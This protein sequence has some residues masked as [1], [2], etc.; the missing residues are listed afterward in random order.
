M[1]SSFCPIAPLLEKYR[2]VRGLEVEVIFKL[3][4]DAYTALRDAFGRI[5]GSK[6]FKQ[7]AT[8]TKDEYD[9]N[10]VRRTTLYVDYGGEKVSLM[11]KEVLYKE[12]IEGIPNA[13]LKIS[14]EI[15]VRKYGVTVYSRSK[16]RTT[17]TYNYLNFDF[18]EV[19]DSNG[20]VTGEFE[21]EIN[22]TLPSII[23]EGNNFETISRN[24]LDNCGEISALLQ[25]AGA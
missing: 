18:T 1:P 21:V 3:E 6:G 23:K 20:K 4:R 14:K 24:L 15:P 7:T 2:D 16:I 10:D 13:I 22:R 25:N 11:K 17:Y 5:A 9:A 19:T 12:P 8:R